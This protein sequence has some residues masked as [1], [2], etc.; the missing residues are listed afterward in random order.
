MPIPI[1][2]DTDP[3]IDDAAAISLALHH[4]QLDVQLIS[5]VH[6]NVPLQLTTRNAQQLIEY[7]HARVP[8]ASGAAAPLVQKPVHAPH[9]HGESGMAGYTFDEPTTPLISNNSVETMKDLLLQSTTPMT[10]VPIG[11]LTNI[12]LLLKM[13]PEVHTYIHQIV[14]MGG[15]AGPG[16]ITPAAEFNVYADPESAHIVFQSGL[17]IVMAGLDIARA[18]NLP[19]ALL[20][21]IKDMNQTGHMLYHLFQHYRGESFLDGLNVYDAYTIMYLC[22]PELFTVHPAQVDV[23]LSGNHA[24]GA[25]FV[26]FNVTDSSTHILMDIQAEDFQTAFLEML[27][28]CP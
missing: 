24:R 14:L 5:T 8:V 27:Q 26:D 23:E 16:N 4:P 1:I 21:E 11:P 10:L 20:P 6:G 13:Y 25:T 19:H 17:P 22:H 2:I 18:S 28:Y 3:G 12:A 7:F 15:S 9:V